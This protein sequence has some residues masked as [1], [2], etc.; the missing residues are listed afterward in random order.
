MRKSA[1]LELTLQIAREF[2]AKHPRR[3]DVDYKDMP[4]GTI[5]VSRSMAIGTVYYSPDEYSKLSDRMIEGCDV[6]VMTEN[7]STESCTSGTW[8]YLKF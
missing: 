4:V 3:L 6:A 2:Q 5:R 8:K 7:R 1:S